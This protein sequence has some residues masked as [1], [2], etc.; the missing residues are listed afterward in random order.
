MFD[1][2]GQQKG[3]VTVLSLLVTDVEV[4]LIAT[5]K[6]RCLICRP[7]RVSEEAGQRM[8][9]VAV[10]VA[11][12]VALPSPVSGLQSTCP[13]WTFGRRSLGVCDTK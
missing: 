11:V 8:P 4:F 9:G 7:R 1:G 6:L 3:L 2:L 10:A 13:L 5:I 12:A